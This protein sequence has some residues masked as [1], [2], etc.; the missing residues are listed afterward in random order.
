MV[1]YFLGENKEAAV[2]IHAF[3]FMS[4]VSFRSSKR[5]GCGVTFCETMATNQFKVPVVMVGCLLLFSVL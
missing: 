2:R 4:G 1:R 5:S 3:Y